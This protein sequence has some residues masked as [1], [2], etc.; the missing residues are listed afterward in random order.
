MKVEKQID[1]VLK[2]RGDLIGI[3]DAA[4]DYLASRDSDE[5]S[6]AHA[7]WRL[8]TGS[9]GETWIGLALQDQGFRR[10]QQFSPSQLVPADLREYRLIQIWNDVLEQRTRREV[11]RVNKLIGQMEG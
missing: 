5:D 1:D 11:E 9:N 2:N 3:M 8:W 6:Q 4:A 7:T 10:S